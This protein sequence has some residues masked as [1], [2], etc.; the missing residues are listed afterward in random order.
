MSSVA[1]LGRW[2][3]RCLLLRHHRGV[4]ALLEDYP[5]ALAVLRPD[6][7]AHPRVRLHL[8]RGVERL[9]GLPH[10]QRAQRRGGAQGALSQ[11]RLPADDV[12]RGALFH[13]DRALVA[14]QRDPALLA[15]AHRAELQA[16]DR[17]VVVALLVLAAHDL[18]GLAHLDLADHLAL[19]DVEHVGHRDG[20]P[21][22]EEA[23][24][25]LRRGRAG[26]VAQHEVALGAV[27]AGPRAQQHLRVHRLI[28]GS[29][30]Q[31]QGLLL[32]EVAYH[33]R[34][35]I[36]LRVHGCLTRGNQE[37]LVPGL[38]ERRALVALHG[39]PANGAIAHGTPPHALH[40]R[41]LVLHGALEHL[42]ELARLELADHV[43]ALDVEDVRDRNLALARAE[44][45]QSLGEAGLVQALRPELAVD[46]G[47]LLLAQILAR[48]RLDEI[49]ELCL[50]DLGR[51]LR[52]LHE[53]VVDALARLPGG[54]PEG[55]LGLRRG[56]LGDLRVRLADG[57]GRQG[58]L[59]LRALHARVELRELHA[60]LQQQTA[61]RALEG[62][63][64]R[65]VARHHGLGVRQAAL[66]V[67][68][69]A[70]GRRQQADVRGLLVDL[71]LLRGLGHDRL[72]GD[73]GV[74]ALLHG[75]LREGLALRLLHLGQ[76]VLAC[77]QHGELRRGGALL[78]CVGLCLVVR[79]LRADLQQL[80]PHLGERPLLRA[81][82]L[83]GLLV[84][85]PAHLGA[86][87]EGA[88]DVGLDALQ[89]P[90]EGRRGPQ[91]LHGHPDGGAVARQQALGH[92]AAVLGHDLLQHLHALAH[93]QTAG[94]FA[95]VRGVGQRGVGDADHARPQPLLE[96]GGSHL[97]GLAGDGRQHLIPL[98]RGERCGVL[99]RRQLR[100][101]LEEGHGV[102]T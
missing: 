5:A 96:D 79:Q 17:L 30:Q 97:S 76:L 34:A 74:G 87:G 14:L 10:L 101:L 3:R 84:H 82:H 90:G 85:L 99:L 39:D 89:A 28:A 1:E 9:D 4:R 20:R 51:T 6:E 8:H 27:A 44:L 88:V 98:L 15:V 71:R 78:Q 45:L 26:R 73:D 18:Q 35:G 102:R 37:G 63:V 47:H 46:E 70:L 91:A 13:V 11:H 75:L 93:V 80:R 32:H 29:L 66:R 56:D 2:G 41:L 49:D 95:A 23:R 40:L 36:E 21:A 48:Q 38:Q 67:V 54:V 81:G 57:L 65:H 50:S 43:G 68:G 22:H 69:V 31:L 62:L 33:R 100:Q 42:E 19:L 77:L 61:A 72:G 55:A 64:R 16:L 94:R 83:D 25:Q 7:D 92:L 12:V 59:A 58:E 60:R 86:L 53:E 52:D 24:A